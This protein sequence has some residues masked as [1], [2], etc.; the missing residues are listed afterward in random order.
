V[1]AGDGSEDQK[2]RTEERG[3]Q[4]ASG[5]LNSRDHVLATLFEVS[6]VDIL[7]DMHGREVYV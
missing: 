3:R 2:S 1:V 7:E 5:V 6:Q 4:P